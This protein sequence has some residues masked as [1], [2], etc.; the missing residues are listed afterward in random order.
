MD[1]KQKCK[2]VLIQSPERA[3]SAILHLPLSSLQDSSFLF[4]KYSTVEMLTLEFV[5]YFSIYYLIISISTC[6]VKLDSASCTFGPSWWFS[7]VS[8]WET[9]WQ[10][11]TVSYWSPVLPGQSLPLWKDF[12]SCFCAFIVYQKI[13]WH[14]IKEVNILDLIRN[15]VIP[16][17]RRRIPSVRRL[18][19]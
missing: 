12:I 5:F 6:L 8:P 1:E 7:K 10:P 18:A 15:D 2:T 16:I 13:T 14:L 19:A 4:W 3:Q 17:W 11:R 9:P